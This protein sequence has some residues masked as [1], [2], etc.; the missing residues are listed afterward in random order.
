[1]SFSIFIYYKI[2]TIVKILLANTIP[3]AFLP[4]SE[5]SPDTG[6][7]TLVFNFE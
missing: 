4:V 1:M 5:T 2:S 6:Q 7:L 3:R